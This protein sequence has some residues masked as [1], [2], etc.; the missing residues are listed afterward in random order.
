MS[1]AKNNHR[2]RHFKKETMIYTVVEA[3]ALDCENLQPLVVYRSEYETPD[4]PKGTIWVRAKADFE[5]TKTLPDG[6]V[7][8]RFTDITDAL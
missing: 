1:T 4:H 3:N 8:E 7:V 6:A 2:Y 5:G